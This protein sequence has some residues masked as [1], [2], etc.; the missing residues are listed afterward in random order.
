M[1][2]FGKGSQTCSFQHQV[3][4]QSQISLAGGFQAEKI[5]PIT[6]LRT[7]STSRMGKEM[8]ATVYRFRWFALKNTC[9]LFFTQIFLSS[10]GSHTPMEH[11]R[12][13]AHSKV[14]KKKRCN[15]LQKQ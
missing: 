10:H 11:E 5:V 14:Y 6:E 2:L 1:L 3:R 15:V 8:V 7:M 4:T 9:V 13:H 12:S